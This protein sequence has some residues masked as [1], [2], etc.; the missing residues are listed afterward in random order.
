MEGLARQM[1][2]VALPTWHFFRPLFFKFA[3]PLNIQSLFYFFQVMDRFNTLS[4][5][6]YRICSDFGATP[7]TY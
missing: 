5:C 4:N 2:D 6:I 3:L 1:D 7:P